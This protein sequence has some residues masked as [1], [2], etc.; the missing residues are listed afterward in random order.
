MVNKERRTR[1]EV[2]DRRQKLLALGRGLFGRQTYDELSIADI[3]RLAGVSKGL[4]YHYFPTK[5]L[6]YLETVRDAADEMLRLT[7]PDPRAAPRESLLQGL[8][9]YLGYVEKNA[10]SYVSLMRGGVG[11]DAEVAAIVQACREKMLTRVLE[12]VGTRK[13]TASQ[14]VLLTGWIGFVEG[15]TLAWLRHREPTRAQLARLLAQQLGFT[16]MRLQLISKLQFALLL[17]K[18][19][20]S[21]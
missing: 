18:R 2:D 13:A 5:R 9:A 12:G 17:G 8:E 19:K 21:R 14:R 7:A 20:A 11:V 4:L 10:S 6:F 15:A 3:A 16:L 1:L